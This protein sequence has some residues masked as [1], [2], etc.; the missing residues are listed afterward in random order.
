M[1]T[2]TK[3]EL[4]SIQNDKG[5][6]M[7]T[8]E[9]WD[10]ALRS[11]KFLPPGHYKI[12]ARLRT[13]PA[14][15]QHAGGQVWTFW[16]HN[17]WHVE[18]AAIPTERESVPH[19]VEVIGRP[20]PGPIRFRVEAMQGYGPHSH[21]CREIGEDCDREYLTLEDAQTALA[22]AKAKHRQH[23]GQAEGYD[24]GRHDITNGIR[25]WEW[26]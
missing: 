22:R 23:H 17:R 7:A 3:A 24:Q 18:A 8:G 26:Q 11:L 15:V 10:L 20:E 19:G 13:E 25:R 5:E 4:A 6:V 2:A 21:F 1:T 16:G 14:E 9:T 12:H